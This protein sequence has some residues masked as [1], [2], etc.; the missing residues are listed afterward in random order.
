MVAGAPT[1]LSGPHSTGLVSEERDLSPPQEISARRLQCQGGLA[2]F[3]SVRFQTFPRCFPPHWGCSVS[4][5]E[6]SRVDGVREAMGSG[7]SSDQGRTVHS[8]FPRTRGTERYA[9]QESADRTGLGQR[10]GR[11]GRSRVG[12]RHR[13]QEAGE[14]APCRVV[15]QQWVVPPLPPSGAG[16]GVSSRRRQSWHSRGDRGGPGGQ[17][18]QGLSRRR[19]PGHL[20]HRKGTR[21]RVKVAVKVCSSSCDSALVKVTVPPS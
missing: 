16:P 11:A 9:G 2:A 15:E 4:G 14:E 13:T 8:S 6:G 17:R 5:R 10:P 7:D 1:P 19:V 21:R 20:S 3:P 18:A 12:S